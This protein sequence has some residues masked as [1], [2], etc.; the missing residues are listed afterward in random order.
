MGCRKLSYYEPEGALEVNPIFLGGALEKNA[1]SE[2]NRLNA[3]RYGFQ[4]QEKDDEIKGSGN[5]INYK[6]RMHDPRLG[7]FMSVDPLFKDYPWN[8]PYAFSENRV[9]DGIDLE[10]QEYLNTTVY[11][12]ELVVL[13][14]ENYEFILNK[15]NESVTK[16]NDN[17]PGYSQKNFYVYNNTMYEDPFEIE[18]YSE[19]LKHKDTDQMR[20]AGEVTEL[21]GDGI[22]LI[23]VVT[24]PF[25][26]A[27]VPIMAVGEGVSLTGT[28]MQVAA[29][30]ADEDYESAL[31]S[32]GA[33]VI[34]GVLSRPVKKS[35][36]K[37]LEGSEDAARTTEIVNS[38]IDA[39]T[40][41]A[42]K[43]IEEVAN[44]EDGD[45]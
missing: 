3:Y 37:M 18:G 40:M 26:G 5:S 38:R 33:E 6:Y 39:G 20:T 13:E 22:F 7:R 34:P 43:A 24:T 8:S 17:P 42:G 25:Y 29:D 30:V 1:P 27:G 12:V 14:N 11:Q 41:G 28:G 36:N 35:V 4:G 9:I 23:G 44:D 10:G 21:V 15:M 16:S 2:K 45:N 32:I 19:W 31:I